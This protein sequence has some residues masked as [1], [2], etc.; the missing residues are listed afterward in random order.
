MVERLRLTAITPSTTLIDAES[1]EWVHV[2]LAGNKSLTVW[3][4]HASLLAE[5]VAD[6]VRYADTAGTHMVE[7]PPGILRVQDDAV[8]VFL[9]GAGLSGAVHEKSGRVGR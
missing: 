3:P 4:G 5:T 1:V 8:T 7:L 2:A 9:A 6:V